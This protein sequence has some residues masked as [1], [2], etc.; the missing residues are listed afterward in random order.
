M[1]TFMVAVAG[2]SS[3]LLGFSPASAQQEFK[4]GVVL[5]L[6]GPFVSGAKD[7]MDGAEAWSKVRGLPGKKVVFEKL[8]DETNPVAATNAF[9]KLAGDEKVKLIYCFV[10]ST[11]AF[12]VK[13]LASE[14]KVPILCSGGAD[15]LG[16]PADP[17][18]YKI[19]PLARDFM[20]VF[21]KFAQKQGYNRVAFLT[22]NDAFGQN[23]VKNFR[24]LAPQYGLQFVASEVVAGEDTNFNAQLTRIK[25]AKPD[26]IYDG[27]NGRLAILTLKQIKQLGIVA[28]I[29][30]SQAA[31][32]KTYF[33]TLGSDADGV[34]T[35]TQLGSL[36]AAAGGNTAMSYTQ[37][38]QA[39]GRTP[40]TWRLL[41]SM[42]VLSLKRQSQILMAAA[43]VYGT[44]S[45]K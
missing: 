15:A 2:L 45:K 10:N 13:A 37:L 41:G 18:F 4:I 9:R 33:D 25:A 3:L 24:E 43:K 32:T 29:I 30:V 19:V 21:A 11:G 20:K 44:P 27:T 34:M 22:A 42:L 17:Y 28:P 5:S 31:L 7:I 39:L 36:G 40:A 35:P 14:F 12:A 23:D 1:K 16:I 6:S 8:D 38:E 26:I